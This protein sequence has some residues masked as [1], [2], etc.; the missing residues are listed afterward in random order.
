MR[1]GR[2]LR[3]L[4]NQ[5]KLKIHERRTQALVV[6]V[7]ALLLG[8]R[9]WLTALGR[10]VA[11]SGGTKHQIKRIDR[12]L[13]NPRIHQ[14]HHDL[15]R[16]MV[17]ALVR[18]KRRPVIIVDW[19]GV[20]TDDRFHL[21]RAAVPVG[22]RTL[23]LYEE[24]HPRTRYNSPKTHSLFLKRL[25]ELLPP[26]CRPI[27]VTDAGFH[28]PWFRDVTA[29]GW[30]WV[31]RIRNRIQICPFTTNQW[32]ASESLFAL[33]TATPRCFG[34]VALTRLNS[35]QC[36]LVIVGRRKKGRIAKNRQGARSRRICS[37]YNAHR[38]REPW[39]LVTSLNHPRPHKIAAL[40][41]SRMQIEET[42]RDLKN[43][44]FGWGLEHTRTRS[45]DRLQVL[46]LIG[47][48][49]TLLAWMI[50]T[51]ARQHH[52]HRALQA[53]TIRHRHVFST[54]MLGCLVLRQS[55]SLFTL[56]QLR[57]AL[58][59]IRDATLTHDAL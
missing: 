14:Q 32:C 56:A 33:A 39:L 54:L 52:L 50:G 36:R 34:Q 8:Q 41:R 20:T 12:L 11:T 3:D 49:A 55:R 47:A 51:L 10:A 46:I 59:T 28:C 2:I 24:V 19:S 43:L 44:M 23:T 16:P 53:N 37:I 35:F 22:G 29:L 13:G 21:L 38:N 42:F 26:L 48:W 30:D 57:R 17:V 25:K 7:E 31:G 1:A 27:I 9:L 45:A 4:L 18:G 6:A 58:T 15:Y 5:A 40:Y